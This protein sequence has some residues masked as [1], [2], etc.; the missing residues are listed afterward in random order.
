MTSLV[1][2]LSSDL[3]TTSGLLKD[4]RPGYGVLKTSFRRLCLLGFSCTWFFYLIWVLAIHIL[5]RMA[6]QLTFSSIIAAIFMIVRIT[7]FRWLFSSYHHQHQA[8]EK[9]QKSIRI[10]YVALFNR[11]NFSFSTI[12]FDSAVPSSSSS[13]S[14]LFGIEFLTG[15]LGK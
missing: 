4:I 8:K 15:F 12:L 10:S 11:T 1:G 9:N 5:G 2:R 14:I 13:P 3:I 7:F 6:L